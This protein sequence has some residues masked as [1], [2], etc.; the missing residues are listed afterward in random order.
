MAKTKI[1][2][3][4]IKIV[5]LFRTAKDLAYIEVPKTPVKIEI[6]VETKGIFS[7]D[8]VPSTKM[9]RLESVAMEVFEHY[10]KIITSEA[11]IL[12][13]K[14]ADLMKHPSAESLKKAEE[15]VKLTQLSIKN[16]IASVEGAALGAVG[17]RLNEEKKKL[18]LLNEAKVKL[19]VKLTFSGLKIGASVARLVAS[20]GADVSS[21]KTIA[22]EVFSVA[23]EIQQQLKNEDALRKDLD[24]AVATYLEL[25]STS[26]S[27]ALEKN[28]L[29][30][31]PSKKDNEQPLEYVKKVLDSAKKSTKDISGDKPTVEVLKAVLK[32]A[33]SAFKAKQND[34]EKARKAYRE[35]TTKT[36]VKADEFGLK[37]DKLS[38]AMKSAT[39]LKDGVKIGAVCMQIKSKA[40]A[41]NKKLKERET[42]LAAI[43][44]TL[45]DNGFTIDDKTIIQKIKDL[46]AA[47]IFDELKTLKQGVALLNDFI[48]EVS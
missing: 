30:K 41:M 38:K 36:M 8:E 47:T 6:Q 12:N 15:M 10:E 44:S 1:T 24:K 16:A 22:K 42:Y 20:H 4:E 11:E 39:N 13:R 32:H 18:S 25:R 9:D 27:K 7:A 43:Q 31:I 14:V 2:T 45:T 26:I 34:A 29:S 46:D 28:G 33:E 23:Q 37:A 35:H 19:G 3:R 48:D 21:Y 17:K 5:D 40:S